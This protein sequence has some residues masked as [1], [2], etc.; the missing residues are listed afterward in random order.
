MINIFF[1]CEFT[2]LQQPL[3]P[4][5]NEMISIGC[6]SADGKQFYAENATAL[7]RSE[8][9]SEFVVET[10]IPLLQGGEHQMRY[11]DIAKNLRIWIE[12]LDDTLQVG[13]DGTGQ[14]NVMM[15]SDAPYFD[16]QHV[17]HMFDNYGWPS[18]LVRKPVALSFP[19]SIQQTRFF[20]AVEDAFKTFQPPLRRHHALD[21]AIA[22]KYGFERATA[23]RY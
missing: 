13:E 23:R 12:S 8:Y 7:A 15:W 22:N 9:F 3:D 5:P 16:W 18:N 19:S 10:V 1:D 20:A 21:D 6:I 17:E 4:E 11:A 14:K 2:K